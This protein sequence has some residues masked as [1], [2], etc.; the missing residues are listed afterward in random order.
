[1]R[2]YLKERVFKISYLQ[3]LFYLCFINICSSV[4]S[5]S[6]S[7]ERD[8]TLKTNNSSYAS[9]VRKAS[10]AV[11]NVYVRR[12]VKNFASPFESDPFF[13]HFFEEYLGRP[14]ER[15]QSSLGSGVI[16][17]KDG[18]IVTNTHVLQG[19]GDIEIRIAL[20]DKREFD[21]KVIL[22]DDK[23]DITILKIQ[24]GQD[25]FPSIEFEDSDKLEVGDIVFAIGNPFGVG[26][27]VT[28]G[29]ISALARTEMSKSDTQLFIQTDAAI[30][31]GNSGGALVDVSGK[32]VGI[33]TMIFSQSGGSQGIGFAIPSNLVRLYVESAASGRK[34]E[35]P[36][37]GARLQ[38]LTHEI[39][40]QLGIERMS[41]AFVSSVYNNSPAAK[42][43]IQP[44]DIIIRIDGFDV[45][46]PRALNYRI[47][48][49][50]IGNTSKVDILRNGQALSLSLLLVEAPKPS[51]DDVWLV[52]GRNPLVGSK[53]SNII[54]RLAEE[55]EIEDVE[56][57][58]IVSIMSGS[59]ADRLGFQTGD[60]IIEINSKRIFSLVDL[61]KVLSV[62]QRIWNI[63]IRR[64][65]KSFMLQI[66]G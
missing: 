40:S 30:N 2:L 54:P 29:I 60:I 17:S 3:F 43:G 59:L 12:R 4:S 9:I 51:K 36:W 61:K 58:V 10:P 13:R 6:Q 42:A 8:T 24:G 47:T 33:N 56:G 7:L 48:T 66:P 52:D 41:G 62:H 19:R 57:I 35:K 37:I 46:D 31:P 44:G 26:Q 23:T 5:V 16:V 53:I 38:S 45:A 34:V 55:L 22:Q 63:S 21:A 14:S 49:R 64:G 50:G 65:D 39:A 18:T 27:T 20:S 1:M 28:H 15:V 25:N 32:L 11:V